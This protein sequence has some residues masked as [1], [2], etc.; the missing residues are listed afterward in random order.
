MRL[1]LIDFMWPL[2]G[3]H[4]VGERGWRSINVLLQPNGALWDGEQLQYVYD[5]RSHPKVGWGAYFRS[6][7]S[8]LPDVPAG[9]ADPFFITKDRL[10][11]RNVD[12]LRENVGLPIATAI[13]DGE[14]RRELTWIIGQ[15]L[16][17]L[18]DD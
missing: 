5:V 7:F 2:R 18:I 12:A 16:P 3:W 1:E 14:P 10:V 11:N 13:Q 15:R 9:Q 8:A 6:A 4:H 17:Q